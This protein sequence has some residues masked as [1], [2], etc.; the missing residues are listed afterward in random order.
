MV[1]A[2]ANEISPGSLEISAHLLVLGPDAF[3]RRVEVENALIGY[4]RSK[5]HI[6][7][8]VAFEMAMKLGIR[9]K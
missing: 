8:E 9:G 7:P 3:R 2:K 5:H 1:G 6:P 4:A